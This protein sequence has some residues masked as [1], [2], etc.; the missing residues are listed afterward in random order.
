MPFL[1]IKEPTEVE[2]L[3]CFVTLEAVLTSKKD[4]IGA[5]KKIVKIKANPIPIATAFPKSLKGA[6][7][8]KFKH[9]NPI[10]VEMVEYSFQGSFP[11]TLLKICL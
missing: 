6:T 1:R 11:S 4:T 8:M 5:I 9:R 7:S 10:Q 2:N 3:V